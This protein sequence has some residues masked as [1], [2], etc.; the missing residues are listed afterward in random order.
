MGGDSG[1]EGRGGGGRRGWRGGR[2]SRVVNGYTIGVPFWA[3]CGWAD[4]CW[5]ASGRWCRWV[6]HDR[7][8]DGCANGRAGDLGDGA[9]GERGEQWERGLRNRVF[10]GTEREK[11]SGERRDV[12]VVFGDDRGGRKWR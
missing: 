11:A 9:D 4:G 3:N 7:G 5:E 6:V 10:D 8:G 2:D 1:G 12:A